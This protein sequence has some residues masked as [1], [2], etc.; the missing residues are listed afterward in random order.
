MK[1]IFINT[2]LKEEKIIELNKSLENENTELK[3]IIQF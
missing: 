2:L 3:E 1:I